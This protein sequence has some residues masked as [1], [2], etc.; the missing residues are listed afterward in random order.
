MAELVKNLELSLLEPTKVKL[1][2]LDRL[3][4]EYLACAKFIFDFLKSNKG[5]TQNILHHSTYKECRNRFNLLG[6]DTIISSRVMVWNRRKITDKIKRLPIQFSSKMFRYGRTKKDTPFFAVSG[7]VKRKRIILPI[8]KN[9]LFQRF[10]SHLDDG[11][12]FKS[13][14]L[15]KRDKWVLQVCVQ[16]DIICMERGNLMGIDINAGCF[17]LTIMDRNK[18][19]LR[20]L[21]LGQDI[22]HRRRKINVR[23][24]KLRSIYDK[25]FSNRASRSL[26]NIKRFEYNFVKTRLFQI[27]NEIIVLANKFNVSHIVIEDLKNLRV[28]RKLGN[29]KGR[30]VN[31]IINKIPYAKFRSALNIIAIQQKINVIAINPYRTSKTCSRCGHVNQIG[32]K[33]ELRCKS[34]G[35]TINRDLNASRNLIINFLLGRDTTNSAKISSSQIPD[36]RVPVTEPLLSCDVCIV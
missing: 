35:F 31:G 28:G 19:I 11:W 23:T 4:S 21:Y 30:K 13:C 14:R 33:R 8:I 1:E 5:I 25:T 22:L 2:Q 32:T 36:R 12:V 10:E 26:R 7:I 29:S 9:R 20:Q 3:Y 27:S 17:A 24:D 18:K 6:A 34:C 15:V 16:N